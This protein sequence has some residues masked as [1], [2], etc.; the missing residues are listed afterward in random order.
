MSD[1]GT[2]RIGL[3]VFLVARAGGKALGVLGAI[4]SSF[5]VASEPTASGTVCAA[6]A[7][8]FVALAVSKTLDGLTAD[9]PP[10]FDT[11]GLANS[12]TCVPLVDGAVLVD[13]VGV[14]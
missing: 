10:V 12:G 7:G 1:P 9:V 6:A 14:T 2:V 5:L 8:L 13:I 11:E 4:V 3:A